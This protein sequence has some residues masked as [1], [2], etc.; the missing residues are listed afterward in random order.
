M[1]LL[2]AKTSSSSHGSTNSSSFRTGS[3][4]AV[5]PVAAFRGDGDGDGHEDD[6]GI[7]DDDKRKIYTGPNPLHN[8]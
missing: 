3:V 4:S 2:M 1:L 8:R 5:S 6:H 7:F